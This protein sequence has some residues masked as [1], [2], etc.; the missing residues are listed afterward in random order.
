MSLP[1]SPAAGDSEFGEDL[2][3]NLR[4]SVALSRQYCDGCADYH[5][6]VTAG[7]L[8]GKRAVA[9]P[10]DRDQIVDTLRRLLVGRPRADILIVGTSD[11]GLLAWA[12]RAASLAAPGGGADF[13]F[14]LVDR[15]G[16]PLELG[17]RFAAAHGLRLKTAVV[18]VGGQPVGMTADVIFVH[19]LLRF[20]P[21][22]RHVPVLR[23]L[24]AALRPGGRLVFSQ[25]IG[26]IRN[27]A[28]LLDRAKLARL[29]GDGA[30]VL[31]E[32]M[33]DFMARLARLEAVASEPLQDY[34]DEGAFTAMFAAAGL[35]TVERDLVAKPENGRRRVLAVLAADQ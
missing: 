9:A 23:E 14:A 20:I 15:C 28:P 3:G 16:T 13:R 12:A 35:R 17:R 1:P 32:P 19:S 31:P 34:D 27:P 18:E 8:V 25:R 33:P 30:I 29:V 7:R 4:E 2:V 21:R 11:G 26:L 6:I 22:E 24:G 5:V 10:I